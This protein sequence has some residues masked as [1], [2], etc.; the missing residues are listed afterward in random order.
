MNATNGDKPTGRNAILAIIWSYGLYV[1]MHLYQ[2]VGVLIAAGISGQSFES[3]ISGEFENHQTVLGIGLA[4][5]LLGIPLIYV[6]TRYLWR[7]SFEWIRLRFDLKNLLFGILI[8]LILPFLI[9]AVLGLLKIARIAWSPG[10]LQSNEAAALLAGYACLAIFSGIA[11][12]VVFR[13][14]AVREMAARYGWIIATIIGGAYFGLAHL[15]TKLGDMTLVNALWI[16]LASI[17]VCF[18][19][20]AMYVRSH[21]LWLPIGFH[22]AWNVCLKGIMGISMSGNEARGGLFSIELS[23][24]P[25]LTGGS[26]GMESSAISLVAYVLV[27]FIFIRFPWRGQTILMNAR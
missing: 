24:N 1:F 22:M 2:Y 7:R 23:G 3:I 15:V 8:G 12:E 16:I 27:A 20:V 5:L 19:F 6:A 4:A 9:V 25:L 17:L 11:E 18:L 26:F 14:M 21:S 13:G 10:L